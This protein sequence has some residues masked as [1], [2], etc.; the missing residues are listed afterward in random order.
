MHVLQYAVVFYQTSSWKCLVNEGL[1]WCC[2]GIRT[3]W[4][5]FYHHSERIAMTK[6]WEQVTN[7]VNTNILIPCIPSS[8][9]CSWG[10]E[11]CPNIWTAH[12]PLYQ[13]EYIELHIL[14]CYMY[15]YIDCI[16]ECHLILTMHLWD[17]KTILRPSRKIPT[18]Q[19]HRKRRALGSMPAVGSS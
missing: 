13:D 7:R 4:F 6:P 5:I 17:V 3:I 11:C 8:D 14:P 16:T 15:R 12:W 9:T 19:S 18:R 2:L 1:H 10:A